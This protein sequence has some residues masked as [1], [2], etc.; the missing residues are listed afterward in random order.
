MKKEVFNVSN[1]KLTENRK[2]AVITDIHLYEEFIPRYFNGMME[3]VNDIKPD[4]ITLVGDLVGVTGKYSFRNPRVMKQLKYYLHAFRDIAPVVMSLG[5]HDIER[6]HDK[7]KREPFRQLKDR[8]I[9]PLDNENVILGDFNFMG[10]MIPKWAYAVDR[11]P[12]RKERIIEKDLNTVNFVTEEDKM[13]ILLSHLPNLILDKYFQ[14]TFPDLYKYDLVLSG[15]FHGGL[16]TDDEVKLLNRTIDKLEKI[17][18]LKNKKDYL[19]S[20]RDAG[21]CFVTLNKN[22][23]ISLKTRGMHE[24]NGTTLIIS[25]G[26]ARSR[27]IDS[28]YIT[29]VNCLKLK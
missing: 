19:E 20:L 21:F 7:E 10:Y 18:L 29:E 5:N 13:N 12:K 25:K 15:H 26:A 17:E 3:T 14:E 23:I 24:V 16:I 9:Y 1:D 22:P 11:I 6:I 8:D 28:C 27:G 2:L 4:Y